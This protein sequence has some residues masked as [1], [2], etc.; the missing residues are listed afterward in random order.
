MFFS[1]RFTIEYE[2]FCKI[3]ENIAPCWNEYTTLGY[4]VQLSKR[5]CD[6][7]GDDDLALLND[8]NCSE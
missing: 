3:M 6:W 2:L 7:C 1:N 5:I 4:F 8:D